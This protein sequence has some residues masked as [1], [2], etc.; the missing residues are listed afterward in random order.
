[1]QKHCHLAKYQSNMCYWKIH[2]HGKQSVSVSQYIVIIKPPEI[3]EWLLKKKKKK[4]TEYEPSDH[5]AFLQ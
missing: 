3:Q 2:N 5:V 4:R 1:M